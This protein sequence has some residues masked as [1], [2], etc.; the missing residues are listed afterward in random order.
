MITQQVASYLIK[1]MDD[2]VKNPTKPPVDETDSL[3]QN[4]I[5][6]KARRVPRHAFVNNM[7]DDSAIVEAFQWR[8]ASLVGDY[9]S[10]KH[11]NQEY[12]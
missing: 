2:V 4:Y 6:E 3:F 11:V 12:H 10:S 8:A 5:R 1:K 7:T 9:H